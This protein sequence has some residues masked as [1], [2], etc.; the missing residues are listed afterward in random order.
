MNELQAAFSQNNIMFNASNLAEVQP[1]EEVTTEEKTFLDPA[2]LSRILSHD[3]PLRMKLTKQEH[4]HAMAI[5][6][7]IEG[8]PDLDNLCDLMYAHLALVCKG[9]VDDA[10]QRC[11]GLQQF[12]Q[13]YDITDT[14]EQG[15]RYLKSTLALFPRQ[16]LSFGFNEEEGTY[17]F[18]HDVG[19]FEPKA[20]T[21]PDM[22][23][24]WLRMMYYNHMLFFPDMESLRKGII[25][26]VDCHGITMRRDVMKH[27][28]AAFN[29]FLAYFPHSG[30]CRLFNSGTIMNVFAATLRKIL[31]PE[32]KNNFCA[33]FQFDGAMADVFLTPT[34]E[35][36]NQR[37]LR[38]MQ[39]ALQRRYENEKTFSL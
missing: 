8:L 18:V 21:S 7:G 33:G 34:M 16:Y 28:R 13:E 31:P 19:Q 9:D 32:M 17:I 12:R 2:D 39:H 5:K 37:M 15:S 14:Y 22:A 36:A 11:Y 24:D 20:F 10:V 35:E 26:M 4:D 29:Q 38:R 25:I 1:K 30:Q 6:E 27:I 3:D 23:D